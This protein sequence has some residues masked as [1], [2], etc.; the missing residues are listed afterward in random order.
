MAKKKVYKLKL[1]V[2]VLLIVLMI[3]LIV[4][5]YAYK[6]YKDYL[7]TKTNEYA[8]LQLGYNKNQVKDILDYLTED[9]E[10]KILTYEYNEFIP[11]FVKTKYFMFKNLDEYLDQVITKEEDFFKYH[12]TD[13]YDYENLVAIVNVHANYNHYEKVFETDLSKGYGLLANKYYELGSEYAP[14]DLVSVP[15]KY[16]YGEAKQIRK[17][18]L[19]QFIK[20]WEA[21]KEETGIYL[22]IVSAYRDYESQDSVYR[23]YENKNG[24][25]YADSIAARPG[26]SEHQ[27]GLSLDIYSKDNT[28]SKTFKDSK[29]YEW[30]VNNS[31]KYGFI[32]RYPDKMS[33]ITGYNY[34]SWHYRYLGVDL[35]TKVYKE[36]ITYDEYYAYYLDK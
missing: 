9:Q 29:A 7:Y 31:Y 25:K 13:G 18:A 32:L 1:W 14:D 23:G 2:K 6:E 12:G 30:L 24:T 22:I 5:P 11:E 3:L 36:G 33:K 27:T 26:F 35:A 10:K 34:E 28:D 19:D 4:S 8:L 17:E 20:M 15:L 16:Y 21:C